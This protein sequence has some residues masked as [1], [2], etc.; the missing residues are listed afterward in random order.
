MLALSSMATAYIALALLIFSPEGLGPF[1]DALPFDGF[2]WAPLLV[3][4]TTA[5]VI[6]LIWQRRERFLRYGAFVSFLMWV[7][8]GIAFVLSGEVISLVIIALPWLLF[9]AYVYLASHF[10]DQTGI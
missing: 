9:Y 10:R 2:M 8:G 5:T 3:V 1:G 4:A 6:G 7:L